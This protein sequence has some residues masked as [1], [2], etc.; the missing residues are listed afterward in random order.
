M[1]DPFTP[2]I[3]QTIRSH[4]QRHKI[5]QELK[6]SDHTETIRRQMIETDQPAQ[7]CAAADR[8]YTT[9]ELS[10]EFTVIGFLAPFVVVQRKSDGVKG[11]MQFTHNP[12]FYF[13]FVPD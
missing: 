2:W 9:S 11:S 6:M 10:A 7:D 4:R 1:S 8:R 3:L 5:A 13:N 12:R